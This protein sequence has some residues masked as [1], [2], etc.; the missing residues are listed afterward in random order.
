MTQLARMSDDRFEI[1]VSPSGKQ[2][3]WL[4]HQLLLEIIERLHR[5]KTLISETCTTY[6]K[7]ESKSDVASTVYATTANLGRLKIEF[8]VR[9]Q[10]L[11]DRLSFERHCVHIHVI[12]EAVVSMKYLQESN[13]HFRGVVVTESHVVRATSCTSCSTLQFPFVYTTITFLFWWF[14]PWCSISG[15]ISK[16]SVVWKMLHENF[17]GMLLVML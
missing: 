1:W 11:L 5:I 8:P 12:I 16:R 10:S 15:F 14:S 2:L 13:R 4:N 7:Q 3:M 9:S 6:Q 17:M